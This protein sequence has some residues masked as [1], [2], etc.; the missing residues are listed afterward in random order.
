MRCCCKGVS[1]KKYRGM[2]RGSVGG[3]GHYKAAEEGTFKYIFPKGVYGKREKAA[4][5]PDKRAFH[6]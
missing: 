6:E 2:G 3:R 4:I 1:E 5:V